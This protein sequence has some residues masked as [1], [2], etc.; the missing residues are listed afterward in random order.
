MRGCASKNCRTLGRL[1]LVYIG[2]F[3]LTSQRG[4]LKCV[5]CLKTV[6]EMSKDVFILGDFNCDMLNP[7]KPPNQGRDLMD[8]MDIFAF[9]NLISGAT[10]I[11]DNS[12]TLLDLVLTNSKLRVL[13]AGVS[14]PHVSDHALVYAILRVFSPK[15]RSQKICFRSMKSFDVDKFC[16]DLNYAPFVTVMN[17]FEGCKRQVI[18][19]WIHV[20]IYLGRARTHENSACSWQSGTFHEWWVEEGY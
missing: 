17:S 13:Q 20:Y 14:N 1:L 6:T 16:D 2:R 19:I 3:P 15:C 4:N 7:N 5:T 8:I 10:R 9:E 18:C 11:T 12:Q